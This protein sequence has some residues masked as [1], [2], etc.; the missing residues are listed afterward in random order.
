ME[1]VGRHSA[2]IWSAYAVAGAVA[3]G[4]IARAVLDW[5]RQARRLGKLEQAGGCAGRGAKENG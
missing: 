4:L 2:F 1:E 3:F 5:R